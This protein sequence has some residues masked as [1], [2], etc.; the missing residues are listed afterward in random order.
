MKKAVFMAMIF[1]A[2]MLIFERERFLWKQSLSRAFIKG[3]WLKNFWK[4]KDMKRKWLSRFLF[5]FF[6][7][8]FSFALSK[9]KHGFCWVYCFG[10]GSRVVWVFACFFKRAFAF[11]FFF[12]WDWRKFV[13]E[14]CFALCDTSFNLC[15]YAQRNFCAY[16][17]AFF[18]RDVQFGFVHFCHF[19][20]CMQM[21]V[22]LISQTIE[23]FNLN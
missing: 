18:K 7:T 20:C 19:F 10:V 8:Y 23:I 13:C 2:S 17:E 22:F 5:L 11:V 16:Q 6:Q 15:C 3:R 14:C 4:A 9:M 21:E 12:V 1:Q